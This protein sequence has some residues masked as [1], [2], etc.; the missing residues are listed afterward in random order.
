MKKGF[1]LIEL[2]VVMAI[3][4]VL[5]AI[6]LPNYLGIRQRANDS[7]KKQ[8]LAQIKNALRLY[9]A[10]YQKYPAMLTSGALAYRT[11]IGCGIDGAQQCP[12]TCG[13]DF[14]AGSTTGCESLYMKKFTDF[15]G[16]TTDGYGWNYRNSAVGTTDNFCLSIQLENS[17]DSEIAASQA[18]CSGYSNCAG[19]LMYCVCSD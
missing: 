4:A 3:I 18:R 6:A 16:S 12:G 17:G 1:T 5:T 15:N 11:I 14:A 9:Y 8:E 19:A 10:D 7:K 2:L 13:G